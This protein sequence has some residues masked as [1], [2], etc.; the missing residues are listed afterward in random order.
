MRKGIWIFCVLAVVVCLLLLFK[1]TQHQ[2]TSPK[3]NDST[4]QPTQPEPPK[5]ANHQAP[6]SRPLV[7]PPYATP[8]ARS[9][10]ATNPVGAQAI[11]LW[12]SPIDFY[13]KVKDE[14]S[15]IVVG[16]KVNFSWV[17]VPAEE[18]NRATNTESDLDGLFSL[19]GAHGPTLIVS[20]SKEGY[21]ATQPFYSFSFG[22]LGQFSPDSLNPVIFYL[23][24]KGK[25]E[26]LITTDYPSFA[27]IAQLHHDG[28]P[29]ELDL[30]NGVQ[31][32]AGSGQLKLEF[33]R[34]IAN[35]N[36]YDWKCQLTVS[37][38]GL[39]ETPEEFAFAAPDIGYQPSIMIDMPTTNQ[40]WKEEIR[41]KYYMQL[42]DGKY[43]R[44]DFYFTSYNGVFTVHSTINP[45]GS[46]NL[47]PEEV[48]PQDQ[49]AP[50]GLPPGGKI[51]NPYDK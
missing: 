33:W 42:P 24:K 28:T 48:Q 9:M 7:L 39:V 34:E 51:V 30:L 16:A 4:N 35:A 40:N 12:Q 1:S 20:V 3:Q 44:I 10:A 15:N 49:P 2:K 18:G 29:L 27:H 5:V 21:Y 6:A 32:L 23:R 17:E 46:R 19:N 47:E 41:S 13:G 43:G 38:G 11:A 37:G 26:S 22:L 50:P 14:N 45:S 8:L 25:G 36:I 31:T